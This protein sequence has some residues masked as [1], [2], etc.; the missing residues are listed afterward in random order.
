[1]TWLALLALLI[2]LLAAA[3]FWVSS[4]QRHHAGLPGGRVIYADTRAWG[5]PLEKPLYDSYLGLTGKPDYLVEQGDQVIPVEVKSTSVSDAPY[6]SHIFQ[7]AAYCMLVERTFGKRPSYG[8]LHYPRRTFAI[9][10]TPELESSV[11]K[12]LLEMQ[13]NRKEYHRSHNSPQRCARC[14]FNSICDQSLSI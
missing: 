4:Q 1:M 12:I 5:K 3:L 2:L 6:D 11:M 9:D 10:F 7:L 13:E 8:I 14:G